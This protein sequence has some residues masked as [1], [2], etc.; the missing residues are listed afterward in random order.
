GL[1][2]ALAEAMAGAGDGN[3]LAVEADVH[4]VPSPSPGMRLYTSAVTRENGRSLRCPVIARRAATRQSPSMGIA[5]LRS[6]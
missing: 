4:R 2:D 5:S 6:Q 3:G 1:R